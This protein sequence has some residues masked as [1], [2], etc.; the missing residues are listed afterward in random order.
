MIANFHDDSSVAAARHTLSCQWRRPIAVL[1][2]SLVALL[3]VAQGVRAQGINWRTEYV[4]ALKE[5]AE[6]GRPLFVNLGTENCY[7]CKQLDLRTFKDPELAKIINERC[8]PLKI[9]A[10]QNPYLVQ[11]LRVQSYP[12]LVLAAP[13][14]TILKVK[15]GFV[16]TPALREMLVKVLSAVGTPDWMRHD[17]EAAEKAIKESDHPRAIAL[18]R[19]VVDDGKNRPV[20]LKARK[21]L[22]E[23]EKQAA[24]RAT[25]AKE[26]AERGKTT[27]AIAAINQLNKTYPGTLAARESKQLMLRLASRAEGRALERKRQAEDL[28]KQA[29]EDYRSQQFLSCLDRC[30]LLSAQYADLPEGEEGQKLA[31]D[32]KTNPEWTRQ[33]SEQLGERLSLLYLSLADSWLKKG[34]PQQAIFYL[35]R[36]I[37]MFPGSRHAELAGTRVARLRGTPAD[38]D[39]HR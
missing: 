4:R 31:A 6:T 5:S 12:T 9:E 38:S 16:E 17:F 28:I 21:L 18:L 32:L 3:G 35:E 34:Q 39:G 1:I 29:R 30:E 10:N 25:Q 24:E 23:L 11:A 13:D 19:N 15:E 8:I 20:Q 27:E 14:G 7:W 22:Q 2:G 36:V 37:K 33:A 26:L